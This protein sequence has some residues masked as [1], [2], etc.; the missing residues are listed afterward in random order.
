MRTIVIALAALLVSAAASAGEVYRW[1][2]KDGRVHYGDKPK[3][4]TAEPVTRQPGQVPGSPVDPEAEKQAGARA[5]ACAAKQR[6]LESYQKAAV[7]NETDSLGQTR[8]LSASEKERLIAITQSQVAE[9]CAAAPPA[10][11]KA[12]AEPAT[13]DPAPQ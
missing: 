5:A 7:I 2:D 4:A 10:P 9:A 13:G 1:V 11:P 12:E 3:T 8:E 6:Q